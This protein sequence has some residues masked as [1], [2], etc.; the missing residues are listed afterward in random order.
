MAAILPLPLKNAVVNIASIGDNT[1][2]T[3]VAAQRIRIWRVF[4][5]SNGINTVTLK[6]G[7]AT[8]LTG[9]IAM[10]AQS[11]FQLAL[12]QEAWFNLTTNTAFII[13][14]SAAIQLS[15]VVQYTQS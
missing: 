3:A 13:N 2:V 4:L 5:W 1:I 9:G 10:V 7:T 11:N 6:D 12:D 15:G 14:L 8:N